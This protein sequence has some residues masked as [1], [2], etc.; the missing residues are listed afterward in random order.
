M[1]IF[2]NEN[3][4]F[5]LSF[6]FIVRIEMYGLKKKNKT[7]ISLEVLLCRPSLKRGKGLWEAE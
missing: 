2:H 4:L 3:L 6:L 7:K 1:L 5:C